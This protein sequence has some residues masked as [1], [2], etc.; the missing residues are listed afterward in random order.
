MLDIS[1]ETIA[2]LQYLLPGFLAAWTSP[3][4]ID[5]LLKLVLPKL[6]LIQGRT[7]CISFY[8][9]ESFKTPI[10]FQKWTD[11]SHIRFIS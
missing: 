8:E 10:R 3:D 11:G 4:L 6:G 9:E 7:Y 5:I 1:T 2:L